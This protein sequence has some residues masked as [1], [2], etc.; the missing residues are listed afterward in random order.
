MLALKVV[1]TNLNIRVLQTS[2]VETLRQRVVLQV[3]ILFVDHFNKIKYLNFLLM[4]PLEKMS[5]LHVLIIH[6]H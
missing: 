5:P 6:S 2:T 1:N 4:Y 3:H